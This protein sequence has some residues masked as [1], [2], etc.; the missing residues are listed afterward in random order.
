MITMGLTL[1]SGLACKSGGDQASTANAKPMKPIDRVRADILAVSEQLTAALE[2]SDAAV[3]DASRRDRLREN[4]NATE[5]AVRDLRATLAQLDERADEYLAMWSTQA[6]VTITETGI[7][8]SA[9]DPPRRSKAKYDEML[10]A[11]GGARDEVNPALSDLQQL[12][13]KL[14]SP[15]K[16]DG[17]AALRQL[18]TRARERGMRGITHLKDAVRKLDELKALL[19]TSSPVP[20]G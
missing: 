14:D 19:S 18:T 2:S 10:A 4:V 20:R 17:D 11:L 1:L 16:S 8:R 9:N 5:S 13:V 6:T 3:G 7:Y 15:N 12:V